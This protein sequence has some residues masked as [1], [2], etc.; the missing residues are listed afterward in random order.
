MCEPCNLYNKDQWEWGL[1]LFPNH[2]P[3]K[4]LPKGTVWLRDDNRSLAARLH[5]GLVG[6]PPT[7]QNKT[8]EKN[9]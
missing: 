5:R 4:Y 8:K 1:S 2:C 9:A 3:S 7:L 6:C